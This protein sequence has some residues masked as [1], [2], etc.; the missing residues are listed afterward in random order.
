V[1]CGAYIDSE[2]HNEGKHGP[3]CNNEEPGPDHECEPSLC[4]EALND[5]GTCQESFCH[6]CESC[7][8]ASNHKNH[9][10]GNGGSGGG[11]LDDI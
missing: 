11:G 10:G 8:N 4:G 5:G 9:H 2:S 1:D 3:P 7:P 6:S